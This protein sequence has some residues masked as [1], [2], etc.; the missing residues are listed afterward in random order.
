[1]TISLR[2]TVFLSRHCRRV[3]DWAPLSPNGMVINWHN[4]VDDVNAVST[5]LSILMG[6]S[7]CRP[8]SWVLHLVIHTHGY[9]TL[10]STLMGTSPCCHIRGYFTLLS[11]LMGASP[12]RPHSWVL[13][14]VIHTHGGTCQ[15][16]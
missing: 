12:C 5:L 14:L 16:P 1:M 15:Y 6:A 2:Y 10:S 13:H 3:S 7:P 4:P 8:Y 9:F 11:T